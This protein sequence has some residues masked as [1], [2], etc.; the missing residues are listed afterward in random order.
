[1]KLTKRDFKK[2]I[3]SIVDLETTKIFEDSYSDDQIYDAMTRGQETN[4]NI[5]M[6]V[7]N[8]V[9]SRYDFNQEA[10]NKI[11]INMANSSYTVIFESK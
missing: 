3:K 10:E 7:L 5:F 6:N 8:Y 11:Y 2:F 4:K 1:M 9:G